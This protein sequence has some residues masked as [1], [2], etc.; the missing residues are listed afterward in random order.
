MAQLGSF[1]KLAIEGDKE[2]NQNEQL[3]GIKEVAGAEE[4]AGDKKTDEETRKRADT[5]SWDQISI[6]TKNGEK[7]VLKGLS[8]SIKSGDMWAIMGPSG[9]G[10]T[11]LLNILAGRTN[12]MT[13][14]ANYR[15]RCAINTVHVNASLRIRLAA[16]VRQEDV[17]FP[18]LTVEE[19]LMFAAMLKLPVDDYRIWKNTNDP[20][21]PRI[22]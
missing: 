7:K 15:G 16:Y 18:E 9:C 20:G 3:N 2:L 19:V 12:S 8:G 22:F 17:F 10:K 11:T 14:L 1:S 6:S 13:Y 4:V 21:N 5:L